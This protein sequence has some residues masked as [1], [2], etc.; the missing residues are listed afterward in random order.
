M[1]CLPCHR[2]PVRD[3]IR[4][5]RRCGNCHQV[6]DVHRG[7]FGNRCEWCHTTTS[8]KEVKFIRNSL[9]KADSPE[10]VRSGSGEDSKD[11]EEGLQ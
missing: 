4:V 7:G 10:P 8:F 3:R 1:E 11:S 9:P 5:D 6:D 2:E